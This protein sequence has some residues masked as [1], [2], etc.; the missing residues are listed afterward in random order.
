MARDKRIDYRHD[1]YIFALLFLMEHNIDQLEEEIR[2]REETGIKTILSFDELNKDKGLSALMG[3]IHEAHDVVWCIALRRMGFGKNRII[4]NLEN[5][6]KRVPSSIQ[7]SFDMRNHDNARLHEILKNKRYA[8]DASESL[9]RSVRDYIQYREEG[10]RHAAEIV[11]TQGLNALRRMIVRTK[12]N[13]NM[14]KHENDHANNIIRSIFNEAKIMNWICSLHDLEEFGDYRLNKT[15]DA[16]EEAYGLLVNG[17]VGYQ[18][19]VDEM[20]EVL[21]FRLPEYWLKKEPD[22]PRKEQK[23]K[24]KKRN[25]K[26]K[27]KKVV[28]KVQLPPITE[29]DFDFMSCPCFACSE[30]QRCRKEGYQKQCTCLELYKDVRRTNVRQNLGIA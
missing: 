11:R 6:Q 2:L 5:V 21:G 19:Y 7:E 26:K 29:P 8:D 9:S 17:T 16:F 20:E 22:Y 18:N 3:F 30:K 1:G 15:M 24:P 4:R 28:E 10:L 27:K 12:Y 25:P 23:P 13:E 14:V